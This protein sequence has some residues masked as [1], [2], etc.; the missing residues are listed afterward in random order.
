MKRIAVL[1]VLFL[2]ACASMKNT[3]IQDYVLEVSRQ[4]E[5]V[6]A[7]RIVRV[8]TAGH[9]W[10]RGAGPAGIPMF[11]ACMEEQRAK[12][13]FNDW[14]KAQRGNSATDTTAAASSPA[15]S[16]A[17]PKATSSPAASPKKK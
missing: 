13:P 7:V 17:A 3:P 15:A 14:L 12:Q 2:T 8:D 4:C 11:H 10:I 5:S 9:Y 16:A 6:S 1:L